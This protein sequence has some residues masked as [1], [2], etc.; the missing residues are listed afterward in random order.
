MIILWD[1]LADGEFEEAVQLAEIAAGAC[2]ADKSSARDKIN[3]LKQ[4]AI[5]R[6]QTST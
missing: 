4:V 6:L 1:I 2:P 5:R 3:R